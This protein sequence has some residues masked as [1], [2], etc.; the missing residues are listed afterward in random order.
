MNN[1]NKTTPDGKQTNKKEDKSDPIIEQKNYRKVHAFP[2]MLLPSVN[3]VHQNVNPQY[4]FNTSLL[5]QYQMP[6]PPNPMYNK[7]PEQYP[8]NTFTNPDINNSYQQLNYGHVHHN[9]LNKNN[10]MIYNRQFGTPYTYPPKDNKSFI[11][12]QNNMPMF[13]NMYAMNRMSMSMMPMQIPMQNNDYRSNSI[14]VASHTFQINNDSIIEKPREDTTAMPVVATEKKKRRKNKAFKYKGRYVCVICADKA[15]ILIKNNNKNGL[16]LMDQYGNITTSFD[17]SVEVSDKDPTIPFSF[18]TS[19]HLTR[20][21]RL[22]S[23]VKNHI[24]PE[25]SCGKRFG[26]KDNMRQHYKTHQKNK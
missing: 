19:G 25:K 22:H 2:P 16:E 9:I 12:Q 11:M 1:L 7:Y 17:Q 6:L 10:Q 24:C 23:G 14:N 13:N 26:R 15:G 5:N 20:H 4:P 21:L 8:G 18:S 3:T